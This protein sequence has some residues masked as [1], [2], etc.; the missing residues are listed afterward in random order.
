MQIV[1]YISEDNL[2]EMPEPISR[3]KNRK[4]KTKPNLSSA[5]S[6]KTVVKVKEN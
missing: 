6:A 5:E 2:Y 3:K 1:S 4:K